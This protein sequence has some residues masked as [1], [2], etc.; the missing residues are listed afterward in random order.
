MKSEDKFRLQIKFCRNCQ[1]PT[2]HATSKS[3]TF[4]AC[5]CGEIIR[6]DTVSNKKEEKY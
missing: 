4:W 6:I 3:E 2:V 5:G 1:R